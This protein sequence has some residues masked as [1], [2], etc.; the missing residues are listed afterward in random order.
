MLRRV[1]EQTR[2]HEE[3]KA[4]MRRSHMAERAAQASRLRYAQYQ[5]M[6]AKNKQL[7]AQLAK[8]RA[9]KHDLAALQQQLDAALAHPAARRAPVCPPSAAPHRRPAPARARRRRQRRRPRSVR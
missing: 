5:V 2:R 9:R 8:H 7:E 4:A 1:D 3:D 6:L